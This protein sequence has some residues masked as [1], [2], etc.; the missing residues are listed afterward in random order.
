MSDVE[1]Q[2]QQWRDES[3]YLKQKDLGLRLGVS[4][5]VV[6]RLLEQIGLR[7]DQK[8]TTKAY[9]GGFVR[10]EQSGDWPQYRWNERTIVPLLRDRLAAQD[11]VHERK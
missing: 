6:G 8:P 3:P 2:A 1:R 4:S 11:Q 10:I 9:T 7:E 5:H